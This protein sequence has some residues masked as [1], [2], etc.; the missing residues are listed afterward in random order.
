MDLD[1]LGIDEKDKPEDRRV[2]RKTIKAKHVSSS[3]L[4]DTR[5]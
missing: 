5:I 3:L 2:S 1:A 4:I